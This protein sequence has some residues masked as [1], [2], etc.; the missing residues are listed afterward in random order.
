MRKYAF[1]RIDR[2]GNH[3]WNIPTFKDLHPNHAIPWF[4][5]FCLG[6]NQPDKKKVFKDVF[7]TISEE[8]LSD[9]K[10]FS[11]SELEEDRSWVLIDATKEKY[12]E[13]SIDGFQDKKGFAPKFRIVIRNEEK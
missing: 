3:R 12:E 13:K 2:N 11:D 5:P 6:Q 1:Q 8:L 4:I 7:H 10:T 9:M